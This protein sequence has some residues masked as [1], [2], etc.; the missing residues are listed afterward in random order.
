MTGQW[1]VSASLLLALGAAV[2]GVAVGQTA[3]SENWTTPRTDFGHPN[4]Q[5]IWANNRA[6]PMERPEQFGDKATL[7][8]EELAEFGGDPVGVGG[9]PG[10]RRGPRVVR[11]ELLA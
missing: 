1:S 11:Q 2:P 3:A 4:L 7:T 8:D 9:S 6:T 10:D 5:G